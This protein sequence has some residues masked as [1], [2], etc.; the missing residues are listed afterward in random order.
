[1]DTI[2]WGIIGCGD[3]TEIKSGPAF[4]KV[5][6]SKLVAVMRRNAEKAEDYARRHGVPRWYADAAQLINDPGVNAVYIATPPLQ[7]EEYAIAAMRAGKPVYVEKPMAIDAAGAERMRKVS[8]ETGMKLTVAHYRREQ[9]LFRKVKE[10]VETNAIGQVRLVLLRLLQPHR[11]KMVVQTA[12]NWR[13][14]SRISGGGL[15]HDLAPHQLDLMMHFFGSIKQAGGL[16]LNQ[17]K[18]YPPDDIV[19]GF[20]RF[21]NDVLFNGTWCF[22]VAES[23]ARDTV[24]I[25]GSEGSISFSVFDPGKL[26]LV[27]E[28]GQKE[29]AFDKLEHQQQ[30]MI[31]KVTAY[32]LDKAANPCPASDGVEVMR[33]LDTFT[34]KHPAESQEYGNLAEA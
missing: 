7:H 25:I 21:E 8:E 23:Q 1:M 32:F 34:G 4:N 27:H 2:Q 11:T 22:T 9:P 15:F 17:A 33:L 18:Y 12:D 10:L 13:T 31:E 24:E 19:S 14:D 16:A 28:S 5:P 26:V 3:V 6:G 20:I 29:F 30:P